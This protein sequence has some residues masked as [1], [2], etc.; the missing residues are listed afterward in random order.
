MLYHYSKVSWNHMAPSMETDNYWEV[1]FD[2]VEEVTNVRY[3]IF[4]E[5]MSD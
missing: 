4:L 2:A 5:L 1:R 3:K